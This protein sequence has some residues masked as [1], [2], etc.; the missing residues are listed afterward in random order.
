M[1]ETLRATSGAT[2]IDSANRAGAA[3][4]TGQISDWIDCSGT[5]AA[6]QHAGVALFPYPSAAKAPWYVADWGTLT[7]NPFW[8]T[9]KTIRRGEMLDLAVRVIVHDG[10]VEQASI[11]SRYQSFLQE[12][13]QS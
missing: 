12:L 2:L 6:G 11:A 5:V 8:R 7:V 3:A 13:D 4:I 9:D 10:D 1:A